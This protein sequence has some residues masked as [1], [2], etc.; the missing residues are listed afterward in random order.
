MNPILAGFSLGMSLILAIGS[1]NAFVL[2]QGLRQEHVFWICLV[3]A[4]SDALLIAMGVLGL[5]VVINSLPWLNAVMRFGGCAFLF[6]Y[7]ARS[8][9]AAF[10]SSAVLAP[11]DA[12]S[13]SLWLTLGVCLGLTW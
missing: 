4:L 9:I 5:G 13:R 10:R 7:G 8:F 2:R 11:S 6:I 1:Q 3:C 12:P